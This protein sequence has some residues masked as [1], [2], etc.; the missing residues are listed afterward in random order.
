[1]DCGGNRRASR[2]VNR[3]PDCGPDSPAHCGPHCPPHYRPHCGPHHPARCGLDRPDRCGLNRAPRCPLHCP[4]HRLPRCPDNR[5]PDCLPDCCPHRC[6]DHRHGYPLGKATAGAATSSTSHQAIRLVPARAGFASRRGCT[7]P[8]SDDLPG[9]PALEACGL[10]PFPRRA[11][12]GTLPSSSRARAR[13]ARL[14][15]PKHA[16][17]S[18]RQLRT[19][20]RP[21]QRPAVR[22]H[23][24]YP[25]CHLYGFVSQVATTLPSTQFLSKPARLVEQWV[26]VS[27]GVVPGAG[28]RMLPCPLHELRAY[29]VAVDVPQHRPEILVLVHR[30]GEEP[31][32][33]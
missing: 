18:H 14:P 15:R 28:P 6:P 9:L 27:L 25:N 10:G 24:S 11:A 22:R 19:K 17:Q 26:K 7:L 13:A 8:R 1:M 3:G 5:G 2:L 33:P 29:R 30:A 16:L 31:P 20:G 12:R 4:V 21:A 23:P 32:L